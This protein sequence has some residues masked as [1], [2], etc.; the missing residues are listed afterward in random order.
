[1][2]VVLALFTAT[3][4]LAFSPVA[5]NIRRSV[6]TKL[7]S[8]DYDTQYRSFVPGRP[9]IRPAMPGLDQP[10]IYDEPAHPYGEDERNYGFRVYGDMARDNARA[11]PP[12]VRSLR[13]DYTMDERAMDRGYGG[14]GSDESEG[15]IQGNSLNTYS[16]YGGNNMVD[17]RTDGRP[18]HANIDM[19]SGPDNTAQKMSLYSQ[20]GSHYG[21]RASLST[22]RPNSLAVRNQGSLEFPLKAS[23]ISQA[24]MDS[25]SSE[26]PRSSHSG[27]Y[28]VGRNEGTVIQGDGMVESFPISAEVQSVQVILHT[29]GMP[30]N[31]KVELLQGPNNVK[32][33]GESKCFHEQRM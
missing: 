30:L 8:A 20:D 17:L 33:L 32:V 14:Y 27:R 22:N 2:K 9:D 25:F 23:V 21:I 13:P 4:A 16:N 19:W 26:G 11:P 1:M 3:S 15:R 7:N 24:Y 6:T 10:G 29:E 28:S 18:L 12:P 31:A 5:H